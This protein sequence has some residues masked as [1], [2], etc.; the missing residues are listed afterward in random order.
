MGRPGSSVY[1]EPANARRPYGLGDMSDV[2]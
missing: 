1:G 2:V